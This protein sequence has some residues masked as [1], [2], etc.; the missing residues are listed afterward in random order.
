M[1]EL[2]NITKREEDRKLKIKRTKDLLN[3]F[4]DNIYIIDTCVSVS[5]CE[6]ELSNPFL[7]VNLGLNKMRLSIPE[8]DIPKY[9]EKAIAFAKEYEKKFNVDAILQTD[10]SG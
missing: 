7:S 6:N 8:S 2:E 5:A 3:R 10:Y 4:F 1:V 9:T